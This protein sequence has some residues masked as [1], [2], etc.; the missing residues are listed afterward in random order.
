[1]DN[2]NNNIEPPSD[3]ELYT[4]LLNSAGNDGSAPVP[5]YGGFPSMTPGMTPGYGGSAPTGK[6][7]EN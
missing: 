2:N 7:V 1:M 6:N 4:A 3:L 5:N